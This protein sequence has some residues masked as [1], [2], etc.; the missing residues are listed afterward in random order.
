MNWDHTGVNIIPG[1]QWK[2]E[3]RG[4]MWVKCTRVDDK[5]QITM[6]ICATASDLIISSNYNLSEKTPACPPQFVLSECNIYAK[7]LVK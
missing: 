3:E 2:L 4:A 5:Y 1:Y 6:V 7:S